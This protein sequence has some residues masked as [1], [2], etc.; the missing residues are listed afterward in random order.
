M[1][2][3]QPGTLFVF[4]DNI[5]C[6]G[7]GGQAREMRGE[8]NAVGIPTKWKPFIDE[9]AYFT[10]ADFDRVKPA[11]DAQLWKIAE[12]LKRGGDVVWPSHGIGTGFAEL[13]IRAPRIFTYIELA[14]KAFNGRYSARLHH[15]G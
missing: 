7:Y 3:S 10:N 14:R 1:M 9:N 11:I 12:H 13:N 8:P 5:A 2:R 6:K 4:G 15:G